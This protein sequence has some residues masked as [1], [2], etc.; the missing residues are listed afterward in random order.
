MMVKEEVGESSDTPVPFL[1]YDVVSVNRGPG[2]QSTMKAVWDK[3]SVMIAR[4]ILRGGYHIGQGLGMNLQGIIHP[5]ELPTQ[6]NTFGLD[7][8]PNARQLREIKE[9]KR[10]EK[11]GRALPMVIP[12]LKI[13]FPRSAV[14]RAPDADEA[15]NEDL[16]QGVAELF[17]GVI[18]QEHTEKD[19]T[20]LPFAKIDQLHN[21]TSDDL[22]SHRV[23]R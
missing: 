8:C 20:E 7:F 16:I 10:V 9:L 21:W 5:I 19:D 11:E 12:P 23:F 14:I 6:M 15:E 2:E 3:T 13:I 17:A 18:I 4:K 1:A 22:P